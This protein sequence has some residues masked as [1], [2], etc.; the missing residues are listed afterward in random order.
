MNNI[1]ICIPTYN[2]KDNVEHIIDSVLAQGDDIEIL[3]VDDNSPDGTAAIVEK[4]MAGN[5]KVHI[6]KR[7]GKMGLGTAYIDGFRYGLTM[8]QIGYLME[9]DADFSHNPNYIKSFRE[10]IQNNDL[11]IGSRYSN[12]ISIVN[13]PM[14]RLLLS[15]FASIYVRV[16][17]GLPVMDPT[18]GFKCFRRK[19]L[20]TLRLD[21]IKSNGYCFQIEMDFFA[22]RA[23]FKIKEIPI[24]F[25][26]RRAGTSK[27]SKHIVFEAIFGVWRLFFMKLF[28]LD[29]KVIKKSGTPKND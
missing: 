25:I 21:M 14:S 12:G 23:G 5:K 15:Y 7:P 18:A 11:V 6:L 24:I 9:M 29:K 28:G 26:D 8:P 19:V 10:Y 13:W 16:V 2:E 17:T 1:L 22:W 3:I 20:E 27:M 4:I